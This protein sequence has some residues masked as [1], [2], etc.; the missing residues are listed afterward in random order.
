MHSRWIHGLVLILAALSS[1][2][3]ATS[4]EVVR[5]GVEQL[6]EP[7]T[8]ALLGKLK[9]NIRLASEE[10]AGG[11]VGGALDALTRDDRQQAMTQMSQ[12]FSKTVVDELEKATGRLGPALRVQLTAAVRGVLEEV[13]SQRTRNAASATVN[14]I[15]STTTQALAH[16]LE[17]ELAPAVAG[18][19]RDNLG[20]ATEQ[21]VRHNLK[22]ALA[23]TT[24]ELT[25]S[26]VLGL[27]EGV[28]GTKALDAKLTAANDALFN[29]FD[30]TVKRSLN[31][32]EQTAGALGRVAIWVAVGLAIVVA[33]LVVFL[34][35]SR[36]NISRSEQALKLLTKSIKESERTGPS[37]AL[38]AAIKRNGR[39]SDMKEGML[40][41]ERF[42]INHPDHRLPSRTDQP[43][44]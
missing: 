1:G 14:R 39:A 24:K 32:G 2:C 21:V 23:D 13:L 19:M 34:W 31:E 38:R 6:V 20:P 43:A 4:R 15:V 27:D 42:L 41:L 10:L 30:L 18:A 7:E 26:A 25:R 37:E 28:A 36:R 9:P 22:P 11:L 5:G 8:Q 3:A 29:R 40:H 16:G 35:W 12:R 33:A 44:E 17:R